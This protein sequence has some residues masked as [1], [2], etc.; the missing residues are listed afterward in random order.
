MMSAMTLIFLWFLFPVMHGLQLT[1]LLYLD[2][3]NDLLWFLFPA[4]VCTGGAVPALVAQYR[5]WWRSTGT[6]VA[7]YRHWW[8]SV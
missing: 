6:A 5:H 1:K 3:D 7:Q 2:D 4:M 8:R